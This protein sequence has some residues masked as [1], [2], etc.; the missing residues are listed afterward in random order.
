M[1]MSLRSPMGGKSPAETQQVQPDVSGAAAPRPPLERRSSLPVPPV[2]AQTGSGGEAAARSPGTVTRSKTFTAK[3]KAAGAGPRATS[4]TALVKSSQGGSLGSVINSISGIKM[5]ALLSGPKMD[6][7][8]SSMKQA[9]TVASKVWGA[10]AS[11]YV[12]SDDEDEPDSAGG[13]PSHLEEN[14]LGQDREDG[15]ERGLI[16]GLVSNGLNQSCTSLGSSSGS[17]DTGRGTHL[18]HAAPGRAGRGPDSEHSSSLSIYQNCSLEVLVSSC[19]QCR[20]CDA[21]VYDEEIM[22]GWTADDSNLNTTCPFCGTAFLPLLHVEFHDLRPDMFCVNANA[23]GESLQGSQPK[24]SS[25]ADIKSPDLLSCPEEDPREVLDRPAPHQSLVPEPV[26]SDP[27]GLLAPQRGGGGGSSLT[28]KLETLLE[29]EGDQVIYTHKFLSQHP[30]I[31]W[32][33]VC[34]FRRLDLPSHLP[35]LILTSE[36]CNG[37]VQLPLTSLHQ[38]SKQVYVQLLWDNVNLHREDQDPLYQRWRSFSCVTKAN[39]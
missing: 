16:P 24:T 29:N 8:K 10:V 34:Y 23:S 17:S 20:S 21:L 4:L 33:L 22:A 25:S 12:Y 9:A 37:G 35:G 18:T 26:Q 11:A 19:S 31:F 30:I 27:L 38:D 2:Q 15:A 1:Y 13:F 32:N 36:H 39:R 3:T 14:V 7:L 28:R 6:V 5:D